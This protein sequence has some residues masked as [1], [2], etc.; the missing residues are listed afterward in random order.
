MPPEEPVERNQAKLKASKQVTKQAFRNTEMDRIQKS[1]SNLSTLPKGA[2]FLPPL[3][4]EEMRQE[5]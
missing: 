4:K 5:S 1:D 3:P 2:P